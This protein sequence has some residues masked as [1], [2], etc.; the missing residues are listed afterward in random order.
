MPYKIPKPIIIKVY[1]KSKRRPFVFELE[2]ERQKDEIYE[3]I[4]RCDIIK[5]GNVVFQKTD[6]RFM[7]ES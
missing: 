3:T 6:F 7:V 2:S 1:L 4:S 5:I